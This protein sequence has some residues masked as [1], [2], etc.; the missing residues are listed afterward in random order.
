MFDPSLRK[1]LSVD[2]MPPIR[3][4]GGIRFSGKDTLEPH[5]F[6]GLEFEVAGNINQ[7]KEILGHVFYVVGLGGWNPALKNGG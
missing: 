6:F 1:P 2:R 7:P 3:I 5:V 4:I